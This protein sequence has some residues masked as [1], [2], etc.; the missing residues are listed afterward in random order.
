MAYLEYGVTANI[1]A[2]HSLASR[3]YDSYKIRENAVAR[4]SIPR[5]RMNEWDY[6]LAVL[7][8]FLFSCASPQTED[9]SQKKWLALKNT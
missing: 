9:F 7:A 1:T 8:V 2:F 3:V 4:G 6:V 5:T